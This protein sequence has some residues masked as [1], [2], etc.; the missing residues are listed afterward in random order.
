MYPPPPPFGVVWCASHK[1]PPPPPP[2]P[3]SLPQLVGFQNT[4]DVLVMPSMIQ[5]WGR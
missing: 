3:K 5:N 1:S 4:L 2:H